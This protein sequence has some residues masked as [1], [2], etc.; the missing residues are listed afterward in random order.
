MASAFPAPVLR[1][2]VSKCILGFVEPG[3]VASTTEELVII[4][5]VVLTQVAE[6][7]FWF[8]CVREDSERSSKSIKLFPVRNLARDQGLLQCLQ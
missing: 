6:S 7:G 3:L 4:K 5:P 8:H 2:Y 1:S